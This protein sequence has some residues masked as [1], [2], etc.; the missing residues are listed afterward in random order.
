MFAREP[1]RRRLKPDP[2]VPPGLIVPE[3]HTFPKKESRA[4][5]ALSH[6]VDDSCRT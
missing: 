2:L 6:T 4:R 5:I 3:S 1:A